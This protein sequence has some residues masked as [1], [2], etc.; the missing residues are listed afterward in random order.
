MV[1][2]TIKL[3]SSMYVCICSI[4]SPPCFSLSLPVYSLLSLLTLSPSLPLPVFLLILFLFFSVP[5]S[6]I[7]HDHHQASSNPADAGRIGDV[8]SLASSLM[9]GSHMLSPFRNIKSST[10]LLNMCATKPSIHPNR[11]GVLD[12]FSPRPPS[13]SSSFS[14]P[15]IH[16][17]IQVTR[18]WTTRSFQQFSLAGAISN[19]VEIWGSACR[20]LHIHPQRADIGSQLHQ[21]LTGV[22]VPYSIF[23]CHRTAS[24]SQSSAEDYYATIYSAEIVNTLT[25]LLFIAL[26][27][28]GIRN[29]LKYG[30]DT[31]FLV[32]FI[33]Y[34]L[35]GSGSFAFH[36]TLKCKTPSSG[37]L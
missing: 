3:S 19:L 8:A 18:L 4:C 28:K 22:R 11:L 34:T 32:A 31:I 26:G 33:G 27:V 7:K 37:E 13:S 1:C 17:S 12:F 35:V 24:F 14:P 5:C 36:S 29:C 15:S 25:N 10:F 30:H 16:T 6:R 23:R 2:A 20:L 21:R 9:Q